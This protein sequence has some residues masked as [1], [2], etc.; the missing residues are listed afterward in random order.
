[1]AGT[2]LAL[3]R[4]GKEFNAV[5]EGLQSGAVIRRLPGRAK[6]RKRRHRSKKRIRNAKGSA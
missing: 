3:G 2:L 1:M 6:E 4:T 5:P